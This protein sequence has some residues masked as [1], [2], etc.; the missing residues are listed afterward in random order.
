MDEKQT[1]SVHMEEERPHEHAMAVSK[2]VA[3][4][5][6]AQHTQTKFRLSRR[7]GKGCYGVGTPSTKLLHILM[8]TTRCL[9]V[10]HLCNVRL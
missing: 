10:L 5:E 1:N 9:H 8:S 2:A 6:E 7:T 3:N 4:Y